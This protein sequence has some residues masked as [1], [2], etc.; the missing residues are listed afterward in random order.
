MSV[1][2][3]EEDVLAPAAALSEMMRQPGTRL[4]PFVP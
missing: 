4:A 2:I 1:S 3:S